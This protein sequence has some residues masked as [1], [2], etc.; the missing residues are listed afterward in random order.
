MK[1]WLKKLSFIQVTCS[2]F[3]VKALVFPSS[4]FEPFLLLVIL[5]ALLGERIVSFLFPKRPDVYAE[6]ASLNKRLDKL[7]EQAG[8]SA[9]EIMGLK[10]GL[11]K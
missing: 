2:V 3:G 5:A 4:E 6:L 11:R 9:N 10:M 8:T 7:S 1:E